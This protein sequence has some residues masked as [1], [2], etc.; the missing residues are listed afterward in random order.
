MRKSVLR[1]LWVIESLAVCLPC[2]SGGQADPPFDIERGN[3]GDTRR[4]VWGLGGR[5]SLSKSRSPFRSRESAHGLQRSLPS[6]ISISYMLITAQRLSS[7]RAPNCLPIAAPSKQRSQILA[8]VD[9][10]DQF[11]RVV[12]LIVLV[13]QKVVSLDQ[14]AEARADVGP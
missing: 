1:D 6:E 14:H 7:V 4:S 2:R 3:Q 8:A 10:R 11:N 5:S 9:H 13:K 12:R